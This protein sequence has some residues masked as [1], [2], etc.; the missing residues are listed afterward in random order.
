[1]ARDCGEALTGLTPLNDLGVGTYLSQAGGLYPDGT[2]ARPVA[3]EAIGLYY[4]NSILPSNLCGL[5]ADR[6]NIVL[7]SI[8]MSSCNQEFVQFQVDLK[9][10]SLNLNS[11][12]ILYNGAKGGVTVEQMVDRDATYW[13]EVIRKMTTAGPNNSG[14]SR[15][16]PRA[17]WFKNTYDIPTTYT[18]PT[19]AQNLRTDLIPV[20]QNIK[21]WFPN[22]N[23]C[24]VTSKNYGG[25]VDRAPSAAVPQR[26]EPLSYEIAWAYKW[27]IED[28]INGVANLNCN[29]ANG[30]VV[31]PWIAWGP[32]IWADGTTARID[33]VTQP[34]S[35]FEEDDGYH[36]SAAGE[37][38]TSVLLQNHFSSDTT[39][40]PWFM[41]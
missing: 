17:V 33:G 9:R 6:G 28:Q 23:L 2:T 41:A 21:Y 5:K 13:Q 27:L 8:G 30:K 37:T 3:H 20:M 18:F 16:Q 35:R 12:L 31:V 15:F 36:P 39:T 24:Y 34:C 4:A 11:S 7:M 40:T 38:Q 26:A 32:Y 25:W 14:I 19:H 1:M 22:V 10:S 29:P